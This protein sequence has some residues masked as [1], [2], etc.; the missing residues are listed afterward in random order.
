[1]EPIKIDGDKINLWG[2]RHGA[3]GRRL[4]VRDMTT[5]AAQSPADHRLSA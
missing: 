4:T 5:V 3:G 1:M 2:S